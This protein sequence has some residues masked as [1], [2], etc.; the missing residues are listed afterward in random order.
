[1]LETWFD[2]LGLGLP[3]PKLPIWLDADQGVFLDLETSYDEACRV[4]GSHD[5]LVAAGGSIP[6]LV[7][8]DWAS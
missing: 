7:V 4:L 2:P 5:P 8:E 6:H 1:M 3:L